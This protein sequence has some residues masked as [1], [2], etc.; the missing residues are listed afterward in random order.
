MGKIGERFLNALISAVIVYI[1]AAFAGLE[2][3]IAAA[4]FFII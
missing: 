4:V 3:G 1:V 2:F